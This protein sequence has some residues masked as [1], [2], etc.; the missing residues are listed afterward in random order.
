MTGED[1]CIQKLSIMISVLRAY[2]TVDTDHLLS[3][4]TIIIDSN[5]TGNDNSNNNHNN[6]G[7]SRT[8][9]GVGSRVN[10]HE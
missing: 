10:S 9:Q 7:G 6:N 2:Y 1:N 3:A 8:R 4:I 5:N